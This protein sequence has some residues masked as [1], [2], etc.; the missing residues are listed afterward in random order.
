M[1]HTALDQLLSHERRTHSRVRSTST[2]IFEFTFSLMADPSILARARKARF[3]DLITFSG[4]PSE[5]VERFLKS[6]K[7]ITK[8]TDESSNH[9]LLEIVRGKL[10]QAAGT[11]FDNNETKFRTW[12]DFELAFRQ[13]YVASTTT[14]K[15]F[16]QLIQRRQ[17]PDESILNYCDEVM[18][19]CRAIDPKMS[20]V[21]IIQHLRNGLN[22]D[23]RKEISRRESAM[24]SLDEFLKYV[25]IEQELNDTSE[26]F[27]EIS[28]D[29]QRPQFDF[30]H[31]PTSTTTA[32]IDTRQH[33]YQH[34][35][36]SY[37]PTQQTYTQSS[38]SRRNSNTKRTDQSRTTS[39]PVGRAFSRQT[40]RH[41]GQIT[42]RRELECKICNRKNHRTIDCHY[43]KPSGCFKCGQDHMVRDCK[44]LTHFQ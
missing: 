11:W 37:R 7:N 42:P 26:K 9:E 27:G 44:L 13:R 12:S 16:D 31:L 24:N 1:S 34:T 10:T 22:P 30:T 25:K 29:P 20:D 6:I 19:L 38:D 8:A 3:D 21:T 35:N 15:K 28:M 43:K 4:Q 23:V 18:D 32:A 33:N 39:Y 41:Q 2:P 14:F 40:W 36:R 5:D 17:K